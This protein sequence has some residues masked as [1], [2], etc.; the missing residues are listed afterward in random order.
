MCETPAQPFL[1]LK[2]SNMRGDMQCSVCMC[3]WSSRGSI[4]Q[5]KELVIYIQVAQ[6][7][8]KRKNKIPPNSL[9][10]LIENPIHH[11]GHTVQEF[12]PLPLLCRDGSILSPFHRQTYSEPSTHK[13]PMELKIN[14]CL[15]PGDQPG[16]VP[17]HGVTGKSWNP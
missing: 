8:K 6:V 17:R 3:T 14:T 7:K 5:I 4:S 2:A 16:T 13:C 1:Q 12:Q 9:L 10:W 11:P 15:F